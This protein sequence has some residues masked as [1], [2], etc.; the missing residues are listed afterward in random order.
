M[1]F[2]NSSEF[3]RS[4]KRHLKQDA[5]LIITNDSC[6]S[7][8]DRVLYFFGGHTRR[9]KL[10]MDPNSGNKYNIS[11]TYLFHLLQENN[12]EL[13]EVRYTSFYIEDIVFL[14]FTL[15]IISIQ[16]TYLLLLKSRVPLR[17]RFQIFSLASFFGRHYI[18]YSTIRL[19]PYGSVR[20]PKE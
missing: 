18:L 2:D 14:P 16:Y 13:K 19:K 15:L 12:F 3:I 7:T 9:F 10:F 5:T 1:C 17:K 4:C 6:L 8:K 20:T 11:I